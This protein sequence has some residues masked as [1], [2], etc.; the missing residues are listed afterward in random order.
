M[1]QQKSHGNSNRL[2]WILVPIAFIAGIAVGVGGLL[3]ATGGNS[4]PSRDVS[5]AAATLSLAEATEAM[6]PTETIVPA[7]EMEPTEAMEPT[8]EVAATEEMDATEEMAAPTEEMAATDAEEASADTQSVSSEGDAERALFRIT[9][10]ESEARFKIDET[11]MGNDIVVVG[12]TNDIAGDMIIN[13]TSP[14]GSQLGEIAVSAR[15]LKTAEEF[16][17]QAIRGRI[18]MS[19]Q[20]EYEFVT[21]EPTEFVSLS[22]DPVAVGDTVEFQITGD[23]TIRDTTQSVTFDTTVTLESEDRL[24][25]FATTDILY[26]DYGI[27]IQ[28]PPSVSGIG[29]VVTLELDFVALKVDES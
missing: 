5:E 25:G 7:E 6:S 19:S 13:F 11:L 17:N 16:R 21:F 9:P 8:E 24:T 4:E 23:L 1:S 12:T 2:V 22:S 10:E 20:D 27:S 29:D 3:W 15:T 28:A 14:A 18:L 26:A